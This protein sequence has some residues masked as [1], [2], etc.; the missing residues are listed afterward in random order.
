MRYLRFL[1]LVAVA[2][3]ST[4]CMRAT[5]TLNLKADGSG[6]ITQTTALTQAAMA[7]LGMIA[8]AAG[9]S[10][11]PTEAKLRAAVSGMGQGVRFVS[12]TPFKANGFDGM[13][14]L[15]AFDDVRKL[16]LNLD[17][18]SAAGMDTPMTGGAD[19]EVKVSLAREGDRSVLLLT[20]PA[21]PADAPGQT[22]M[23]DSLKNAPPQVDQMMRTML[24][25]MLLEVA[26]TIDGRIVNTNAPFV[27]KNKVVLL[28]LDGA[29]LIK[30][31]RRLG[32]IF[33]MSGGVEASLKKIP[34]LKLSLQ[35]VRIEF[36]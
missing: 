19:S 31:G 14:A 36:Q 33:D 3:L 4:G 8:G 12:A 7:Q 17:R 6:T 27:E 35:P 15:Y 25:T 5:Y 1:A 10:L 22:A 16:S 32:E 26:I 23:G 2:A 34:G 30:S 11:V 20:M 24:Q 21:I 18:I 9:D 13:T 28:R 29:E